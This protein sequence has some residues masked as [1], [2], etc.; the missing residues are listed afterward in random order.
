MRSPT[1]CAWWTVSV[2]LIADQKEGLHLAQTC[3]SLLLSV[4]PN[5]DNTRCRARS[6]VDRHVLN[7]TLVPSIEMCPPG[8]S[9][10]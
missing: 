4:T 8:R 10:R 5:S 9:S 2:E 6:L 3:L 1:V 7:I